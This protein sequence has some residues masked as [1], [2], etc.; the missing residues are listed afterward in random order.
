MTGKLCDQ[1]LNTLEQRF[2]ALREQ[3][4]GLREVSGRSWRPR[5][6]ELSLAIAALRPPREARYARRPQAWGCETLPQHLFSA[7]PDLLTVH[8]RD[9]SIIMSNWHG[10][11]S[12]PE[13][14]RQ[15]QPKCYRVYHHRDRPC[16]PCHA[17]E[18]LAAGQPVKLEK[19]DPVDGR[20]REVSA[21]PILDESGR[22]VLVVEHVRDITGRD[23][24]AEALKASEGRFRTLIEDIPESLLLT[25]VHRTILAASRVAGAERLGK[26]LAEITGAIS[27][28]L[29]PPAV[30]SR[31]REFVE[32][33]V[34]T[35]RPVRF[36]DARDNFYFDNHINPILDADGKVSM[37]SILAI[38]ITDRKSAE[39]ALKESEEPY[40][41]LFG[42]MLNGFAYCKMFFDQNQPQDSSTLTSTVPSKL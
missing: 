22:V 7:I 3:A 1:G 9:F 25:D 15:G 14:E 26:S 20:V 33:A 38:D 32:Q 19:V 4:G 29:F 34:A 18:V 11:E 31:R 35:G 21:Y 27:F 10:Y 5:P 17:L 39:Q 6:R 40:R 23:L 42:N 13:A 12:V 2:Q 36:E 41:S 37:L 30:A 24:A 28:D 16:E 8:D